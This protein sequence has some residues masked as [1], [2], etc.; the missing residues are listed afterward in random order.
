MLKMLVKL[1]RCL[2]YDSCS[3]RRLAHNFVCF[4][5]IFEWTIREHSTEDMI[6][7][8]NG[9]MV[10]INVLRRLV[11]TFITVIYQCEM[12]E[13]WK[14]KQTLWFGTLKECFCACINP[15]VC[16]IKQCL[17]TSISSHFDATFMPVSWF[18]LFP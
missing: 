17:L 4:V 11:V 16:L 15:D 13:K 12:Y 18:V 14:S 7:S 2:C 3:I 1:L 5:H 9:Q 10:L 8:H 6:E